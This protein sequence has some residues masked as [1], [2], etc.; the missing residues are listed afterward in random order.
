MKIIQNFSSK[1]H[2]KEFPIMDILIWYLGLIKLRAFGYKI[3]LYCEKKDFEFLKQ[4]G[5]F[6]LYDEIDDT[7]LSSNELIIAL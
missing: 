7:F 3:K 2:V 1:K 4:W 5:L 6:D